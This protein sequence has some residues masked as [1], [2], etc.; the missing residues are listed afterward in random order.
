MSNFN[1][2]TRIVRW[3]SIILWIFTWFLKSEINSKIELNGFIDKIINS[4]DHNI[5]IDITTIILLPL[6]LGG[7][8][9][10][11]SEPNEK[12]K[13]GIELIR[14]IWKK[15]KFY[16][17]FTMIGSVGSLIYAVIYNLSQ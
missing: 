6:A 4:A 9:L 13:K 8:F 17:L 5:P 12:P 10:Y 2:F 3:P 11:A 16:L 14:H 15:D 1:K 7:L